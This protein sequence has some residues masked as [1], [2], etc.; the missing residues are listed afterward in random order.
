MYRDFSGADRSMKK[1]QILGAGCPKCKMLAE[2]TEKVA[3]EAGIEFE[4]VKVTDINEI[5]AHNVM[6]T[7]AL[8]VDGEVRVVGR[9]PPPEE[10]RQLII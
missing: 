7:P 4:L 2:A 1:I 8:V 5:L 10:I 3:R 6:M 9:I